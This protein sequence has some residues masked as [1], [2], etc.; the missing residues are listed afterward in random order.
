MTVVTTKPS[1]N[2]HITRADR[3]LHVDRGGRR[4]HCHWS[5]LGVATIVPY[6]QG[7]LQAR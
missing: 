1:F 6:R 4:E 2:F 3:R 7:T 5:S